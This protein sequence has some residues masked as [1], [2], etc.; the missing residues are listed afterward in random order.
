MEA[1][2]NCRARAKC[3]TFYDPH[4]K[5]AKIMARF[6]TGLNYHVP[7]R[8]TTA[9]TN[10]QKPF[11]VQKCNKAR[12]CDTAVVKMFEVVPDMTLG[13]GTRLDVFLQG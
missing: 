2:L 12:L 9:G 7:N 11:L 8:S 10:L 6:R 13:R 3:N 5:M 1:L 4:L